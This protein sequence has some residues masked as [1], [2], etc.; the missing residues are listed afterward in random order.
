VTIGRTQDL[1]T[2]VSALFEALRA[3][4][5][6]ERAARLHVVREDATEIA[7]EVESL[8]AAD[9]DD[10]FLAV[11]ASLPSPSSAPPSPSL[12]GQT[13]GVY[14]VEREIGRGGM[15]VVYAGRHVDESL[16]KRVAIKT[17]VLGL[18]RPEAVWRFRRERQILARLEHPNIAALYDGG[19]TAAGLPYLVMEFVDG[20]RIDQWCDAQQ[21]PV[22]ARLDLFRQVCAAVDFAHAKLVV[23]RDL[24]PNNILVTESGVVKLLD[25]GVAKLVTPD[26]EVSGDHAE[27]T[28]GG[29]A[30]MTTAYASP[31]QVRGEVVTTASDVFSLGVVLYRLLAGVSPFPADTPVSPWSRALDTPVRAPSAAATESHAVATRQASETTLRAALRGE[32]DAIVLKAMHA[33][34]SRRYASAEALRED[35]LRHLRGQPVH[36]QPDTTWYRVRKFVARQRALVAAGVLAVLSLVAGTGIS[37]RAAERANAEAARA[38]SEATRATRMV[39]F[40]QSVVGA[41][42]NSLFGTRAVDMNVTL[43]AVLDS[44]AAQV[45]RDFSTDASARADLYAALG[46]SLRR[47]NRMDAAITLL[48]SARTLHERVHGARS[49][50][51]GDDMTLL[52]LL[53]DQIGRP[54]VSKALLD[55]ALRLYA[56]LPNAPAGAATI[57][58]FGM[59]QYLVHEGKRPA[60]GLPWLDAAVADERRA[61]SPRSVLIGTIEGQRGVALS[62]LRRQRASDSAFALAVH[63]FGADSL[64]NADE[65]ITV[66]TNWAMMRGRRGEWALA[67]PVVERAASLTALTNGPRHYVTAVILARVATALNGVRS[68]ARGAALADSSLRIQAAL[69]VRDSSEIAY[70]LLTRVLSE[71]GD[72]RLRAAQATLAQLHAIP[73]AHRDAGGV[74]DDTLR[75]I[76]ARV[77]APAASA[78]SALPS[79]SER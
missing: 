50:S 37:I 5:A 12:V 33:E 74:S 18:D 6:A 14:R 47:F 40:L 67:L 65:L 32:L 17:L 30:P 72:K 16:Q 66:L 34:P 1:W 28:R 20:Q 62:L 3:L 70:A 46:R 13:I 10:S 52:A 24:K 8:L 77:R 48:D 39:A 29:M 41:G 56:Q 9:H 60:A 64:R 61:V 51:V 15:G 76:G 45:A 68:Y 69:A 75:A 73:S 57:A 44:T 79:L 21:L 26:E 58:R 2:C 4:P 23:H 59:G 78:A 38:S 49:R 71:V 7:R 63:A 19:S 11:G 35:V 36:A 53:H 31:E 43:R 22:P 25:F 54:E 27:L 55:T 42:D